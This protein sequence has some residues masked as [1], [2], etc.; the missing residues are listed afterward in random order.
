MPNQEK[1]DNA[2]EEIF[3][4]IE[5]AKIEIV[6]DLLKLKNEVSTDEYIQAINTL[7]LKALLVKK[8]DKAKQLFIAHNK[9]VLEETIPF[10]DVE[11]ANK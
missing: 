10:G 5:K 4:I 2:T 11:D 8:I 3:S 1:I 7:D 6:Q 9:V